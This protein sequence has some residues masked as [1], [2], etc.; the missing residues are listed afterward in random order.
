MSQDSAFR[1]QGNTVLVAATS[2]TGQAATN[3]APGNQSQC[4][5]ANISAVPVYLAFGTSNVAV[6]LPT[7]GTP[8]LGLALPSSGYR[9]FTFG[10]NTANAGWISAMTTN[11]S[12]SVFVTPGTGF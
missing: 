11:G 7:T 1:P 4:Y 12:A 9:C 6:S 8:S 2:S 10:P 5:V 3:W